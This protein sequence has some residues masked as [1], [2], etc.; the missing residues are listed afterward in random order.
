MNLGGWLGTAIVGTL[1]TFF[2][3]LTG[4]R[5]RYPRLQGSTFVLWVAGVD[6]LAV[7]AAFHTDALL[8]VGWLRL[9]LAAWLLSINL[10]APLRA[11]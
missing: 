4:T 9:T 2:P 7:G 11:L 8:G 5:L 10:V 1:H 3:S 6:A